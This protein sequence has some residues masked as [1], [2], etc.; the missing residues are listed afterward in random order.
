LSFEEWLS[1]LKLSSRW[2]FTALREEAIAQLNRLDMSP[3]QQVL[4]ARQYSIPSWLFRGYF[5]ILAGMNPSK[6][7]PIFLSQDDA[8]TLGREVALELSNIALGRFHAV[9]KGKSMSEFDINRSE[10]LNKELKELEAAASRLGTS[11]H[12]LDVDRDEMQEEEKRT[13]EVLTRNG[14]EIPSQIYYDTTE[15]DQE[16]SQ[17]TQANSS[18]PTTPTAEPQFEGDRDSDPL[19]S[20][21]ESLL[22]RR[23]PE[24]TANGSREVGK[25]NQESVPAPSAY[26]PA[27]Q[28]ERGRGTRPRQ[29]KKRRTAWVEELTDEEE[30]GWGARIRSSAPTF[31]EEEEGEE[32]GEELSA[33]EDTYRD[34][35]DESRCTLATDKPDRHSPGANP[36]SS[37]TTFPSQVASSP[38]APSHWHSR[39]G[40]STDSDSASYAPDRRWLPA[41]EPVNHM[42]SKANTVNCSTKE[43][44]EGGKASESEVLERRFTWRNTRGPSPPAP[45]L[46]MLGF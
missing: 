33:P 23:N 3:I 12:A 44:G 27:T 4:L 17:H 29:R 41:P 46:T 35:S 1:V 13:E 20:Y 19:S 28:K 36:V 15:E 32:E 45:A 24:Q 10:K 37:R 6:E 26:K 21:W 14:L 9:L 8:K 11:A 5:H 25:G 22:P 7:T 2:G 40:Y 38:S 42:A 30:N 31:P 18:N 43:R 16:S 34:I 39:S